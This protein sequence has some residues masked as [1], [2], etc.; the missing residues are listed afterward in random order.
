MAENLRVTYNCDGSIATVEK[1]VDG[2]WVKSVKNV[3]SK[4]GQTDST[5]TDCSVCNGG[6]AYCDPVPNC[7]VC[8]FGGECWYF[9][10]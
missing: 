5:S 4:I 9:P 10:C 2:T 6:T 7:M 3:P 1:N 8:D